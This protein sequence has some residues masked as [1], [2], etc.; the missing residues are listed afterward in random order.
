MTDSKDQVP[1]NLDPMEVFNDFSKSS[2]E[3]SEDPSSEV[4]SAK[5]AARLRQAEIINDSKRQT[6]FIE[7]FST[8]DSW[9][10]FGEA[11]PISLGIHPL[12]TNDIAVFEM[13]EFNTFK[14][15]VKSSVGDSLTVM[16]PQNQP[17]LWRVAPADFVMWTE[18]QNITILQTLVEKFLPNQSTLDS[19]NDSDVRRES[20]DNP[21]SEREAI[22]FSVIAV[23]A[24]WPEECKKNGDVNAQ[25]IANLI[26]QRLPTG[27]NSKNNQNSISRDRIEKLINQALLSA[28]K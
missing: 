23:L 9:L 21:S 24:K 22:L 28:P 12:D 19:S 13:P 17:V 15:R 25:A 4:P 6:K 2:R 11:I 18:A 20:F 7:E 10:V 16:N 26:E 27:S 14:D 3:N 1:A 8:H 5:R